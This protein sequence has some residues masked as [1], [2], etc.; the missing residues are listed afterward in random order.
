MVGGGSW[1]TAI[2]KILTENKIPTYWYCRRRYQVEGI[3]RTGR[4]PDYLHTVKLDRDLVTPSDDLLEVIKR[5]RVI[6]FVVPSSS[7]SQLCE[8]IP[9]DLLQEKII[10]SSIKG[11]TGNEQLP[12]A[13]LSRYFGISPQQMAL[14]AGPCHAEEVVNQKQTYMTLSGDNNTLLKELSPLFTTPYISVMQN[15]DPTGVEYAAIY[16]NVL[17]V[18]SGMATGLG[19]GDNFLAVLISNGIEELRL[20]IRS[21]NPKQIN[22]LNSSYVGDLLVTGFSQH[23]R[24]RLFGKYIGQGD[25]VSQALERMTMVAEGYLAT[26]GLFVLA[27][28]LKVKLPI[29]LTAHRILFENKSIEREFKLLERNLV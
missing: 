18:V 8:K 19:Y 28:T 24:N 21:L 1:A 11:I 9:R 2:V 25:T 14:I 20:I 10:I 17:G 22:F 16:K 27:D 26:K 29:L 6:I 23:S 15:T 3:R 12:T 13:Y 4:N 7:L 5:S